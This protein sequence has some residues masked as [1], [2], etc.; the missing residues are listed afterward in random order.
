L[1]L[2][3]VLPGQRYSFKEYGQ[4]AG[5]TNLDV[6]CLMQDRTGFLWVGTENG[7][8]RYDGRQFRAY[9]KAQGL[10]SV[11]IEALH[12]TADGEIWAGTSQGL[13][14]LQGE[15]FQ[16]VRSGPGNGAH[17]IA[18]DARG[19]L[20]VG[21]SLGLLVA[22][23][24]G[25]RGKREFRLHTVAGESNGTQNVYGIAVE[26]EGRVWYGCGVGVCLLEGERA[27]ILAGFDV[28]RES[29]RGFLIDRQGSLWVRSYTSLIVLAKGAGKFVRYDAGLPLSALNPAVLMDRDGEIYVPT[30]QGLARRT[31]N[32]WTMIRKANGL[33]SAPVDFFLQDS[34]GSAWIALDGGGLVRWRGYKSAETWTESEGL[35]HDVVWSLGR[36]NRG[37]FWA[38]TQAGLSRFLAQRGRWQ[39]WKHPLLGIGQTLAWLA[40]RDGTWWAGQAPG[41]LFHM[42]PRTGKAELYGAE[43]GL[44]HQWVYNLATDA[45]GRIWVGTG[46]GLYLGSRSGGGWRFE[47]IQIPGE[48]ARM[49]LAIL[50]DSRGRVWVCTSAGLSRLENGRWRQFKS[51]DGLLHDNVTY[52]A[53]APDLAVWVGYR[54]PIGISRLE[55]DGDRLRA[56]HFGPKDG[57]WAA[58]PYFLRF[59]R[60][61]WLWVGTDM[62]VDRY[63]G[64]AWRHLD[65]ADG[66]A[67]NDCDVN[68]FFADG[69]GS[70]WI[71]T[72]K[73]LSH[74]LHPA[75]LA[76]RPVNPPVV[77]TWLRLGGIA[78]P[79]GGGVKVP[80]SRRSF[81][82]GFAALTF[83][84]EDSVRFRHRLL[85]LDPTWTETRQTEAHYAGLP[86][87]RF[88]L[89]VQAG[90][91][92]GQWNPATARVSFRVL[93]PWWLSW[94]AI[95]AGAVL[96]GLSA[97]CLW[98]WRVR[99]ILGRQLELERAV[100]DRTR[101]LVLE[102]RHALQEKARA[103]REKAIVEEQKVEIEHLLRE[104]QQAARAKSEFLANMSHEIRTPLNGI[105]GMTDVVLQSTLT[106]DQADC[107]RLVKVSADSLLIVINDILDFSKIEAGKLELDSI[108][109]D[110]AELLRDALAPLEAIARRKGLEFWQRL[111]PAVPT[112]LVGDPGRLR[113]V[114]LNLAG[115]AVKFT[116][117]GSVGIVAAEEDIADNPGGVPSGSG[118]VPSG[119][120]GVPSESPPCQGLRD[121][122]RRVHFQIRDTGIGIPA[123]IQ[124]LIFEPFRQAD[125]STSRRHGGTGL[126]LSICRR[127]VS[128]MGGRIWVESQPGAGSTFH[129]TIAAASAAPPGPEGTPPAAP[130]AETEIPLPAG[131]HVL[132][133]EDNIVNQKLARRMLEKAGCAVVCAVDGSQAVEACARDRFDVVLMDVQMPHM[134]GLE[135]TAELRRREA[136]SGG[137]LP[138]IALTAN[139]MQGDRERCLAAG[140]D[141]FVGKPMKRPEL[142]RAIA[143]GLETNATARR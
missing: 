139:V 113:Q 39:A 14:R 27:R 11:Q 49:I 64:K 94:W 43:S 10:P 103:E 34:E 51:A 143:S 80:Y 82:A 28:P 125:G 13:A 24:A 78:P 106:E 8:F 47:R 96:L 97:R 23:P 73:G 115:N 128:M 63:D 16:T 32:G 66:L 69:D 92:D 142:L 91:A 127:L 141:G 60:R 74:F 140:M 65:K 26:S 99:R 70:V 110:L 100:E 55:F 119:S 36:D 1:L 7:L 35:S 134:D 84:N 89:E 67:V 42:D 30:S 2:A 18:S 76:A 46:A 5:L 130:P 120:S 53:E 126:G 59:D 83:V 21:T 3:G 118:G 20:Y 61:G 85:G 71:G 22:P 102:Q 52:L 29:W 41:G 45:E 138:I 117:T 135:A 68:A 44:L 86:P 57:M 9:T 104:T 79:P 48:N 38:A 81:S 122:M 87:G 6:Y 105:M 62:G 112:R 88:S 93:P 17:A 137:H 15:T 116:E 133:A 98:A 101:K 77:L 95:S 90:T 132:L 56:R 58:K 136:I 111:A 54:D 109:F 72:T 4:D 12:Q 114:L 121:A 40:G 123:E 33:P 107:L 131:L 25:P 75:T 50:V 31:A 37:V 129:F 124:A 19:N 108:E